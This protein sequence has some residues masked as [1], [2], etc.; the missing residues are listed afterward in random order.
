[1]QD[2][3]AGIDFKTREYW[4][5]R[6]RDGGNSGAGSYGHLAEFKAQV[7]N[8]FIEQ[9]EIKSIIEWGCGDGNQLG[10]FE[11]EKYTGYDVAETAIKMCRE[12]YANDNKKQFIH[13][14]GDKVTVDKKQIWLCRWMLFIT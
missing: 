14:L 5:K 12:K 6:Y 11:C 8:K 2:K 9:H 10:M 7:I 3:F 4:E 1:M 13:Y